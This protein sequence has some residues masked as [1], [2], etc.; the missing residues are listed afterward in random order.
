MSFTGLMRIIFVFALTAAFAY[1]LGGL[2]HQ[3]DAHSSTED[4]ASED[5]RRDLRAAQ[6]CRETHG[7]STFQWANSGELVCIPR[8]G[9]KSAGVQF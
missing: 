3:L 1:V 2:G 9:K 7:E 5:Y 6:Y 4:A 8:H